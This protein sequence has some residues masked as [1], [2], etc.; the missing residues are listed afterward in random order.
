MKNKRII[1]LIIIVTG[2]ILRVYQLG[3]SELWYDE[4]FT[5]RMSQ[6]PFKILHPFFYYFI[7][8]HW[9]KFFG[10]SE[11]NLRILPFIFGSC[12]IFLIYL[13]GREIFSSHVGKIAAAIFAFSPFHIWYAQEARPYS[14]AVFLTLLSAIFYVK[15]Q[16]KNNLFILLAFFVVSIIGLC[17]YYL[18][19]LILIFYFL[20]FLIFHK[21]FKVKLLNFILIYLFILL[22]YLPWMKKLVLR[23]WQINSGFW[24]PKPHLISFWV[25]LANFNLGYTAHKIFYF[26]TNII[27]IGIIM[28]GVYGWMSEKKNN[29]SVIYCLW[30]LSLP[31]FTVFTLS[32]IFFSFYLSRY[33]IILSP[34][35]YLV[36]GLGICVLKNKRVKLLLGIVLG[37]FV[38]DSLINYYLVYMPRP[39]DE[40]NLGC[41]VK[42]PIKPVIAFVKQNML[43]TDVIAHTTPVS[44]VPFDYY[45]GESIHQYFIVDSEYLDSYWRPHFL[46]N[47]PYVWKLKEVGS[48]LKDRRLW[49]I[50]S[51]W[52]RSG[53]LD[54]HSAKVKQ[55]LDEHL[56]IDF[57]QEIDGLW[58]VRYIKS[59]E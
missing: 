19:G 1:F 37:V 45:W 28:W 23:L 44:Y 7:T 40:Y 16:Q 33:L 14:L 49:L 59:Y 24:V 52:A 56:S 15:M 38:F 17:T 31:L 29:H 55:Y 6:L 25:V 46:K 8:H 35:Y 54:E 11:F 22:A 53:E 26:V 21:N 13:L 50:A 9:I 27:T 18:F 2:I 57:I 30:M 20:H 39:S 32:H 47:N 4:I 43:D 12:S 51:D 58:I 3:R 48:Q 36:L 34:F 41:Y 5:V 10:L 42:K